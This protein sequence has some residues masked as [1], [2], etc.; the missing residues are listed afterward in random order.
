MTT[1]NE[2][3]FKADLMESDLPQQALG[4][5]ETTRW[6]GLLWI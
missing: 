3:L 5:A 6:V 2:L 1:A 4:P